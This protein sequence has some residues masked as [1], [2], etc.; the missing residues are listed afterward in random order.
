M[1]GGGFQPLPLERS[2]RHVDADQTIVFGPGALDEAGDLLGEGYSLLTT[3]RAAGAA[4]AVADRAAAVVHVPGG[5]VEDIAG[6][7]RGAV[8]R[9]RLV[10]LGGGRVIDAAKAIAA[11]EGL[12]GPVAIPTTLSG[13]EMTGGHRHARGVPDDTPRSRASV[14]INDP[15]LSASQ[16]PEQLAASSANALGHAANALASARSTPIAR[17]VAA[18]AARRLA[19]GW[20]AAAPDRP[21]VA[22]GALLAGWAVDRS[23]LGP[24]HALSQT[25]VRTASL[26]HAQANA[27]LLPWTLR[28]MRER[29]PGVFARLDD[30]LATRLEDVAQTL[31][32]RASA[33]LGALATDSRLLE[34]AVE[35]A[36]ARPELDRIP[37]ALTA[38]EIRDL[39]RAA[40]SGER[41][42]G[43]GAG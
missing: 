10:A 27:A 9:G 11:A 38:S 5:L 25:L 35:I 3:A 17:A 32:D 24:H 41:V 16:P 36:S 6:A 34:R 39:Y 1:P 14:V 37:P 21:E 2:F 18:E 23:G 40:A 26:G 29:L 33:G 28:A 31:S 8:P 7:L 42:P 13:A 15:A 22:L 30:E 20:A 19:R 43:P 4:P 12:P